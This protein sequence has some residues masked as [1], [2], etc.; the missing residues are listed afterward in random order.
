MFLVGIISW[1]YGRGW[2]EQW[3][4][5]LRRWNATIEQFSIGTLL[6]TLFAP[7]RQISAN[8]SA[9][10]AGGAMRAFVDQLISRVIGGIIRTF[11][12]LIGVFIITLQ[13]VYEVIVMIVWP[14]L[15]LFPIVG[16]MLF[17]IGWVPTWV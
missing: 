5:G 14:L 3:R 8:T 15:P 17:A 7:F 6:K 11:T 2:V 10:S 4:Q 16:F 13:I 9:A 12:I 1:W